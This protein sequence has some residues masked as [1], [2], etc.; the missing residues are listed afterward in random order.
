MDITIEQAQQNL[1]L[2]LESDKLLMN[3]KS[4][5]IAQASLDILVNTA[6]EVEILKAK[7][8]ELEAK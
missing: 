2:V 8:K 6:K 5:V 7:I 3:K 4:H 1:T